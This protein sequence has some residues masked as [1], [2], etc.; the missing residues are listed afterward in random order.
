M[1]GALSHGAFPLATCLFVLA[2]HLVVIYDV[3]GD[4]INANHLRVYGGVAKRTLWLL[5]QL[6]LLLYPIK[7]ARLAECMAAL[8]SPPGI[9]KDFHANG[10]LKSIEDLLRMFEQSANFRRLF[11]LL[12]LTIFCLICLWPLDLWIIELA[13]KLI[14]LS[15]L[16]LSHFCF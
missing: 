5:S 2:K 16:L 14:P 3:L 8:I 15:L 4:Q 1:V 11:R 13:W 6:H 12:W 7:D 10:A 9:L